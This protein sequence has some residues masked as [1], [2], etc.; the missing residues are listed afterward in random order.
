MISNSMYIDLLRKRLHFDIPSPIT[1]KYQDSETTAKKDFE[2]ITC[3]LHNVNIVPF[4]AIS[5]CR[6]LQ[7][8]LFFKKFN[9]DESAAYKTNYKSGC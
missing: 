5:A 3:T 2:V 1:D 8:Q 4:G 9:H 7:I 6:T